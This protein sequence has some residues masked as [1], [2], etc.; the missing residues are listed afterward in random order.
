[1]KALLETPETNKRNCTSAGSM[2]LATVHFTLYLPGEGT[3]GQSFAVGEEE[4]EAC[5]EWKMSEDETHASFLFFP[6]R[7]SFLPP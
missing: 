1:L 2:H 3:H 5:G 4:N 6:R 7:V